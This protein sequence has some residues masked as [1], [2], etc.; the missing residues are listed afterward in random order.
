MAINF[1]STPQDGEEYTDVNSGT[2]VYD[3]GT[4]SWTLTAAGSASAFNFR[5]GHDFTQPTPPSAPINSGDLWVHDGPSGA[6]NGIYDGLVDLVGSIPKGQLV[7]WD[8][9]KYVA[10]ASAP[11]YPDL[12]D[13]GGSTL[14]DRYLKLN[15]GISNQKVTGT[16]TIDY[17][18]NVTLGSDKITLYASN[19]SAE[20]SSTITQSP[21][22]G[23]AIFEQYT[24]SGDLGAYLISSSSGDGKL[25]IY[26]NGSKAI[27]LDR[28]SIHLLDS[29][30]DANYPNNREITLNGSDG[31]AVFAGGY[32]RIGFDGAMRISGPSS[33]AG[34][35]LR[36]FNL[37]NGDDTDNANRTLSLTQDGTIYIGGFINPAG[38]D[39]A[40]LISL[41]GNDVS[42]PGGAEFTGTVITQGGAGGPYVAIGQT[43][44]FNIEPD[45]DA[46][47]T[48]TTDAEGIE[49]RVYTGPTL[50]VKE[51]LQNLLARVDAMEANEVIDDAT[52]SALLT[53]VSNLDTRLNG[54]EAR[55]AAL[56][57]A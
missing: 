29:A 1:P 10:V 49:T 17:A 43:I 9:S 38:G 26:K 48:V 2:W 7:L 50:D 31:T 11:G 14:D 5:G 42:N 46:N 40:P 32:L 21:T 57:A 47:Y 33:T 37:F 13:G 51:R 22:L 39:N 41:R 36:K 6:V 35:A 53:L 3:A 24:P 4:N 23:S 44:T 18:G 25:N 28:D 54:I 34:Y 55:I 15:A 12:G 16:G 30:D 45:N 56:E 52:D 8:G 19:G 27:E 20:F